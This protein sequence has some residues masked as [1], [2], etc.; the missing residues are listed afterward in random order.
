[1]KNNRYLLEQLKIS[2][3]CYSS[4]ENLI[5]S[6]SYEISKEIVDFEIV[7]KSIDARNKDNILFVF[8]I[9]ITTKNILDLKKIKK[10]KITP[11]TQ[12]KDKTLNVI[13]SALKKTQP[14]IVGMGPA[15][16][17]CALRFLDY[18]IIPTIIE[19]GEK[20][21]SRAEKVSSFWKS[22]ILDTESNVMF[23]EGGA[24]TFSDGKLH[25]QVNNSLNKY[26]KKKLVLFGA[27]DEI[28]FESKPH[29]GTDKLISVLKKVRS[30]LE[31]NNVKILFSNKV[32]DIIL[33][34][35]EIKE[36]VLNNYQS[37]LTNNIFLATGHSAHDTYE[38]L[39]K[40]GI[41]FEP[42]PFAAGVRIEHPQQLINEIQY[43]S[44][45]KNNP[46]LGASPYKLTCKTTTGRNVFS[47]CMC[48]GGIVI[49]SSNQQNRL[50]ING[51][52]N[53]KRNSEFANSA[54]VVS[55][56]PDDFIKSSPVDGL[57]FIRE[58]EK[59]A[60]SAASNF[61]APAQK[62]NDFLTDKVSDS[63]P[64]SSYKPAIESVNL[65]T[66]Y[67][68]FINSALKEAFYAFNNKMKGFISNDALLI[69]IETR[70]S[71]PVRLPRKKNYEHIQ[72]KGLYP[73]G[74]GSGYAGG[75]MS[76]AIDG[77][78]AVDS[79]LS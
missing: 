36:V 63:L 56:L 3:N 78:K 29:I 7:K 62:L 61:Q 50:V 42:K 73:V 58:Y 39:Y 30:Y 14:V 34:K 13:N 74:E 69:G 75:I 44:K 41:Y 54:I 45:N 10:L 2:V 51:M 23:G 66:I 6:L 47:F 5:S 28:L 35:T 32:I 12:K 77:I 40:K 8:T 68:E 38:M 67:P 46:A 19:R 27:P 20:V 52:S 24:G 57:T 26:I 37:I 72:I 9:I 49:C 48:P 53:Y 4:I 59:R 76:S 25:T 43:G 60:F 71:S 79:Y 33:K 22:G 1:M 70:T 55:I 64:R 18:G 31:K 17:F 65:N 16:I 11:Y 21:E 15:G